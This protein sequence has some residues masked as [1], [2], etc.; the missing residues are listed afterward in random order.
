MD[1]NI[2]L[3]SLKKKLVTIVH[4]RN[5]IQKNSLIFIFK[6]LPNSKQ[7]NQ[8]F[9]DRT[10]WI[11]QWS[12]IYTVIVN[13]SIDTPKVLM[14]LES[15]CSFQCLKHSSL[16]CILFKDTIEPEHSDTARKY[17]LAQTHW[18][19]L[20][21]LNKCQPYYPVIPFLDIHPTE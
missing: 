20:L 13:I 21:K 17:K 16:N 2:K 9:Y 4:Y 18:Q 6:N 14:V 10:Q 11:E 19:C 12:V 1:L 15:S 3:E 5:Y 7:V 8:R